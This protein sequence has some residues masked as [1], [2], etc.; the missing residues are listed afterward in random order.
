M[1]YKSTEAKAPLVSKTVCFQG[2]QDHETHYSYAILK[3]RPSNQHKK[4]VH[5]LS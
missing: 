4:P 2:Y 5:F 3:N 1:L